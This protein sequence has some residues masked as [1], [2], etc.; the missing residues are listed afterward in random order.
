VLCKWPFMF[1][2]C[3]YTTSWAIKMCHFILDYN[4][5]VWCWIFALFVPVE[6]GINT[7]QISYKIYNFTLSM[8]PHI[9][10]VF[11]LLND[12]NE[13]ELFEVASYKVFKTSAFCTCTIHCHCFWS[14]AVLIMCRS[15]SFHTFIRYLQVHQCSEYAS[16]DICTVP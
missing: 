8:S 6:T 11:Y 4:F 10:T 9:I 16:S 5:C 15:R 7:L 1:W 14:I 12:K 13:P 2:Y 3:Y